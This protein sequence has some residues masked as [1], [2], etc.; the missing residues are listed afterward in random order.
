MARHHRLAGSLLATLFAL[1][2]VAGCGS[3][4]APKTV[5]VHG[6]V[7]FQGKPL[8]VG[9]VVFQP[10]KPAAGYPSRPASGSLQADGSFEMSSFQSG[11][12][13]VPGEYQVGINTR[14]SGPTPENPTAAE[15][16]EAPRRYG[17]PATSG[18]RAS[19]PADAR[20]PLEL[21]FDLRE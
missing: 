16:W 17:D 21:S 11:D 10:A 20:G 1:S 6:K 8:T 7:T 19:V 3:A 12:G 9:R 14:T 18:F 2:V 5:K 13:V 4:S 15:V